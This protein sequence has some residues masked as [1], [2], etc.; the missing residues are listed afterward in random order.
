MVWNESQF[1]FGT[2]N[3]HSSVRQNGD[4]SANPA[5]G[6]EVNVLASQANW[7]WPAAV[8]EIF[9][10]RGVNL[11]VAESAGDFVSII[12]NKR[13]HTT[14][15]EVD[16]GVW[17]ALTTIRIIRMDFPLMPCIL[18]S[19][20]PQTDGEHEALLGNA[21]KL[22]VFSVIDKPVDMGLLREQLNRLFIRRYGSHIFA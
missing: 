17:S 4:F 21:L 10:P 13:I 11:L 16:S 20:P 1:G 8:R 2:G 19:S 5:G 9:R 14:I 12:K 18:L 6:S 15:L 22:N 7:A 3:G